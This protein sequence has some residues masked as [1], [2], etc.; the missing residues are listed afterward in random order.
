MALDD[1][2][3]PSVTADAALF[4][5]CE[6]ELS[7]LLIQRKH[8]P[9]EGQ[10]ALPGGFVDIDE[11]LRDAAVRE[12]EEETG[13]KPS[14]LEQFGAFGDP[15]R[16][17]RGRVITV[18]YLSLLPSDPLPPQGADDAADARWWPVR[19]PPALAFDHAHVLDRALAHLKRRLQDT[20]SALDLAPEGFTTGE[21]RAVYN[22]LQELAP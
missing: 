18:A 11:D 1:Y 10:W 14:H 3:Q 21:L 20:A 13:V 16:D 5:L 2:A 8:P 4:A 15:E 6:G 19:D 17:P 7:V 12:L 22:A 9:F